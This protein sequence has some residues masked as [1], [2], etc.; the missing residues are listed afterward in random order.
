MKSRTSLR[1]RA[2][3]SLFLL[4]FSTALKRRTHLKPLAARPSRGCA[5]SIGLLPTLLLDKSPIFIKYQ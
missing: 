4:V 3:I 2:E 5:L 1:K